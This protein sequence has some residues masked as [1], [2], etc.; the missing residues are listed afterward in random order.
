[1]LFLFVTICDPVKINLWALD[2]KL[3]Y[4]PQQIA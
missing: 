3:E 4:I 1:M 2:S